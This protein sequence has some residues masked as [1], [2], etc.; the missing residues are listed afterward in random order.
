MDVR[1]QLKQNFGE[2]TEVSVD[3][4]GGKQAR[5]LGAF[6]LLPGRALEALL[7]VWRTASG[8]IMSA[9]QDELLRSAYEQLARLLSDDDGADNCLGTAL[10]ML[11][12]FVQRDIAPEDPF[13]LPTYGL[14]SMAMT[15]ERGAQKYGVNNWRRI[16]YAAQVRH[17]LSHL[18]A[19]L[20]GNH[21]EDHIGNAICRIGFAIE[22]DPGNYR[23]TAEPLDEH[24]NARART[25]LANVT[26]LPRASFARS[27][28]A[29]SGI[30][31][32]IGR[33]MERQ[34][35]KWGRGALRYM[36]DR[37]ES[38]LV[39]AEELLEANEQFA[40]A[41]LRAVRRL[42]DHA[43]LDELRE[44]LIQVGACAASMILQLDEQRA[45]AGSELERGTA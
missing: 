2:T 7:R 28:D 26:S 14:F 36:S 44:E 25:P 31:Q 41:A 22:V 15:I 23:F 24:A 4:N 10:A 19:Y 27:D 9:S 16:D 1:E 40:A 18:L 17:A 12:T 11:C 42:N 38:G 5:I 30:L 39:L 45:R 29:T 43:P 34:V 8:E 33:E 37:N 32:D 35:R 20:A 6:E 21:A 3:A 13:T